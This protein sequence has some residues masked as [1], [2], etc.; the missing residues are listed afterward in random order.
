MTIGWRIQHTSWTY[1]YWRAA[2]IKYINARFARRK[3][4]LLEICV[5][6]HSKTNMEQYKATLTF[7]LPCKKTNNRPRTMP[8]K[9]AQATTLAKLTYQVLLRHRQHLETNFIIVSPRF[10]WWGPYH[11]I[12][13]VNC[14]K[15]GY[16]RLCTDS[17]IAGNIQ[18]VHKNSCI[19]WIKVYIL[20]SR[21]G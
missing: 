9:L 5:K 8:T 6:V 10:F 20:I 12:W 3:S 17:T 14:V 15:S 21:S 4:K 2:L 19:S 7:F 1:D 11:I 13:A 16:R 18:M